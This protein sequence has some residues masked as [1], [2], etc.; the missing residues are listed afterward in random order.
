MTYASDSGDL[1]LAACGDVL[2]SRRL[3]VFREPEYLA[4]RKVLR[5]ADVTLANLETT[6]HAF[7]HSP[8]DAGGTY[9]CCD[10]GIVDDLRWIGVSLLSLANNHAGDY[11][12]AGLLETME[13]LRR[14]GMSFAGAGANLAEAAGPCY[15]D[16]A[17]GR[18]A[19]IACCST[20]TPGTA[21]VAQRADHVGRPGVNPLRF[22][23]EHRV[24]AQAL[25]ALREIRE[26][27][28]LDAGEPQRR[29]VRGA[30][31]GRDA[32]SV[33]FLGRMFRRA[34]GFDTVTMLDK[35][36]KARSLAAIGEA[37]RMA[38]WVFVSC[39]CH[40]RG[41]GQ[42]TPPTFLEEFARA[43]IEAGADGFFGHGPHCLRGVEVHRDR[44]IFYSLGNFVFQP[45]T[46]ARQPANSFEAFGLS[47]DASPADFYDART[48]GDRTG[49]PAFFEYWESI[50]AE[51]RFRERR[52]HAIRIHPIELGFGH[53]RWQRGRPLLA[54]EP[55]ATRIVHELERLSESYGTRFQRTGASA[56]ARLEG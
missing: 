10:P 11:G 14:H 8:G 55:T 20:L 2:V 34:D 13:H 36:D 6:L 39:H 25:D 54:A 43:C 29:N 37:R 4:L 51:V 53:P 21:A 3:S 31:D 28:G 15:V 42:E 56:S 32:D 16:T 26:A 12:V 50:V 30:G 52:L 24:A 5:S 19:L 40:E 7:S 38:D 45:D 41:G 44:P 48:S 35:A 46:M 9:S 1:V 18:V 22:E 49:F 17:A 27:L 23:T 47:A 33:R